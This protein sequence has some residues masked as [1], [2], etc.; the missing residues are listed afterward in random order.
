MSTFVLLDYPLE[1]ALYTRPEPLRLSLGS[2]FLLVALVLIAYCYTVPRTRRVIRPPPPARYRTYRP[3]TPYRPRRCLEQQEE[4]SPPTVA[5]D[6][7]VWDDETYR[8]ATPCRPRRGLK[9]QDEASPSPVAIDNTVWDDD[10]QEDPAV[11]A[12]TPSFETLNLGPGLRKVTSKS[13]K[14][15]RW[16]LERNT[17]RWATKWIGSEDDEDPREHFVAD[18]VWTSDGCGRKVRPDDDDV[19]AEAVEEEVEVEEEEVV[20]ELDYEGDVTMA[21]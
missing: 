9:Q 6:N 7:T 2:Q 12:I 3:A 13:K 21:D 19:V 10:E 14:T 17:M 15:V 20:D 5:I 11:L 8:P 1:R 16:A 4:V 18:V